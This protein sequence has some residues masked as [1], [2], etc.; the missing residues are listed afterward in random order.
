MNAQSKTYKLTCEFADIDGKAKKKIDYE[1]LHFDSTQA[2][3]YLSQLIKQLQAEAYWEA[4]VMEKEFLTDTLVARIQLGT[5]YRWQ[6][7]DPGNLKKSILS[8]INFKE[9][10]YRNRLFS[11]QEIETL[12]EEALIEAEKQGF[13]FAQINLAVKE[14]KD[15]KI[16][17]ELRYNSGVEMRFDTLIV[18]GN[19]RVKK[20]YLHRLL[21]IR[22]GAIY[23]QTLV[24]QSARTLRTLPFLKLKKEPGVIFD[25]QRA[26]VKLPLDQKKSNQIDGILG[27][28]PNEN[29]GNTLITGEF[30]LELRNLFRSGK[31][32]LVRWQ[33]LQPSSQSLRLAYTHPVL[34]GS[35]IDLSAGFFLIR[36]DSS[37]VNREIKARLFYNLL[38]GTKLSIGINSRSSTLGSENLF[39]EFES[40]PEVSEL[41][42]FT[43]DIGFQRD[44]TDDFFFPRRGSR[45]NFIVQIG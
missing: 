8:A 20:K 28:L 14:V 10:Y 42:Y 19:A 21:N 44:N 17:A 24:T 37:F 43:Y 35:R 31:E 39:R 26:Y 32:A 3:Y 38:S 23:N 36:Q 22:P 45:V 6:R 33:S 18:E 34:F 13:P 27:I 4:R 41:R 30:N 29:N 2:I 12:K 9:K 1:P 40:L 5:A 15:Y 25:S 7:L 11:Y 16:E